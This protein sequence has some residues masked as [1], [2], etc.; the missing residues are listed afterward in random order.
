MTENFP[1]DEQSST[2]TALGQELLAAEQK[3][4]DTEAAFKAAKRARDRIAMTAIPEAMEQMG[5]E[6]L[7]MTGGRKIEVKPFLS[8]VPL[9]ANRPRVLE[10]LEAQGAGSLIKT[11]VSVPF[12]RGEGDKVKDLLTQLQEAGLQ[13]KSESKVE[14]QT[15][16][17]HVRDRLKAGLPVDT[18]LFGVKD[19][20]R[21]EFTAGK[22][23]EAVFDGE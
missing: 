22:P 3:V 21:A 2:L 15:L 4:L 12:G 9:A 7:T 23:T 16:K 13:A 10:E 11:T 14:P 6:S 8:V 20:R 18:E 19:L 17:K 5:V 1:T